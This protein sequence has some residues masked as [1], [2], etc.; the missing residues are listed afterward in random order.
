MRPAGFD[1]ALSVFIGAYGAG[2][3]WYNSPLDR[4]S[5]LWRGS[6]LPWSSVADDAKHYVGLKGK[7]NSVSVEYYD[8][9]FAPE[10]R[11]AL[12]NVIT[13]AKTTTTLTETWTLSAGKASKAD[14][15][16]LLGERI[17]TETENALKGLIDVVV[18][19]SNSGE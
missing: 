9:D 10:T 5:G 6:G 17:S 14:W 4:S 16:H 7:L 1:G 19:P 8:V 2:F 3:D 13:E 18:P 11:D 15:T 12:G